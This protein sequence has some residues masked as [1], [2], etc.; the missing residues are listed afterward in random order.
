MLKFNCFSDESYYFT[1]FTDFIIDMYI[2]V[3][4][5]LIENSP[6]GE[7]SHENKRSK[8]SQNTILLDSKYNIE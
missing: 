3:T 6:Q 2:S 4:S 1:C 5:L 8:T 7:D